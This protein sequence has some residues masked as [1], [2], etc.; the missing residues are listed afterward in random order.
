M[1]PYTPN[2]AMVQGT[3]PTVLVKM[4]QDAAKDAPM[5]RRRRRRRKH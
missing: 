1:I 3:A 5:E 2:V 4:G